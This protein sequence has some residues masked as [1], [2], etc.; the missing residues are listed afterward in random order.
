MPS[1]PDT[2]SSPWKPRSPR[3]APGAE[4][5]SFGAPPEV[6]E[7]MGSKL[8]AKTIMAS[9]GVPVLAGATVTS[10]DDLAAAAEQ[11]GWPV[12]VKAVYGGGGR[13]MR[14]V[15]SRPELAEAVSSAEREAT[16]AFGD[17]TLFLERYVE[18]PRHVE[19][20]IFGD[21]HGNVIHLFE[22]ECSIQRRYQKIIEEAPSPAVDVALRTELC[23][24]AVTAARTLGYVG[25][26]TVEFVLD[27]GAQFF[28]LEVNTR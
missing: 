17:G 21:T 15:R 22:R 13:G 18:A 14:I 2:G 4:L 12:L 9:P 20:Q 24:A 7:S 26:G 27:S 11:V 19:V 1:I 25:A 10:G 5:G 16:A 28:F 6:I 3:P 8:A 23:A